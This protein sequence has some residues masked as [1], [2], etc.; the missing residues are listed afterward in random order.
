V[1]AVAL[2][3]ELAAWRSPLFGGNLL[4]FHLSGWAMFS[5]THPH[6]DVAF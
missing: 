2:T 1:A 3:V 5:L 4:S 6:L